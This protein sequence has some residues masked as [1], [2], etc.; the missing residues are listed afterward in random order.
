MVPFLDLSIVIKDCVFFNPILFY[1]NYQGFCAIKHIEVQLKFTRKP[2]ICRLS[3]KKNDYY[4]NIQ[5]K[6]NATY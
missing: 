5:K 3:T 2:A 4:F 6:R 1:V